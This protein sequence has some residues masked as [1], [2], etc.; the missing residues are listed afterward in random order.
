MS[1][2]F[3]FHIHSLPFGENL[4]HLACINGSCLLEKSSALSKWN[5]LW[6]KRSTG[7][8]DYNSLW[9]QKLFAAALMRAVHKA[10]DKKID[11]RSSLERN[12][13]KLI[14]KGIRRRALSHRPIELFFLTRLTS[15]LFWSHLRQNHS[16]SGVFMCGDWCP[17]SALD[18]SVEVD[19]KIIRWSSK[20]F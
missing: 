18:I 4:S 17:T 6:Q 2:W 14:N 3:S 7:L 15:V 9:L 11:F 13:N 8:G 20:L 12:G 16:C 5:Y 1:V 19:E 10:F